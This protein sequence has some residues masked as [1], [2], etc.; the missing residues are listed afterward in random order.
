MNIKKIIYLIGALNFLF[1]LAVLVIVIA[2]TDEKQLICLPDK[3][4]PLFAFIIGGL[5]SLV[6][7]R[8]Q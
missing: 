5:V 4:V 2:I 3:S 1:T 8:F 7:S 6:A